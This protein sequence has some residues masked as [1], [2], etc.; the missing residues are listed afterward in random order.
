MPDVV[1]TEFKSPV[2]D[3]GFVSDQAIIRWD[4]PK[5]GDKVPVT[6]RW[7][8]GG[9]KPDNRP[10][11]NLEQ[12]PVSGMIMVGDKH[13]LMTGGRPNSPKILLP[14]TEWA[15]FQKN[16]VSYTHLRAHETDSYL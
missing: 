14:G 8:E 7:Y 12:L 2:P 6:M 16:P 1:E 10:E 9:L 13:C 4:F 3:N 15:E 11:W 5:R